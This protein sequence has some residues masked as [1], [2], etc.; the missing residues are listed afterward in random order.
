MF[1]VFVYSIYITIMSVST[2]FYYFLKKSVL[3]RSL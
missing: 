2:L 1:I 3:T